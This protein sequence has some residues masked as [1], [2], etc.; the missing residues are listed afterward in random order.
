MSPALTR[1]KKSSSGWN[2]GELPQRVHAIPYHLFP[3]EYLL[4]FRLANIPSEKKENFKNV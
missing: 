3:R 2:V 1:A 4:N